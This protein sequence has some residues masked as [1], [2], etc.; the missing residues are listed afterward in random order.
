MMMTDDGGGLRRQV[1]GR[2]GGVASSSSSSSSSGSSTWLAL[3]GGQVS[4]T[5]FSWFRYVEMIPQDE[6]QSVKHCRSCGCVASG[7]QVRTLPGA[8]LQ[9]TVFRQSFFVPE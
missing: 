4:W 7:F 8:S 9:K 6:L 1:V 3:I 2:R 5:L